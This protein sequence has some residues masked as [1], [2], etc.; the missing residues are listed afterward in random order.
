MLTI[1]LEP[2]AAALFVKHLPVERKV[3]GKR[4]DGF[5]TFAPGSSYIVV[6]AG[7]LQIYLFLFLIQYSQTFKYITFLYI[8]GET[9][10]INDYVLSF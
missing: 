7:G 10:C 3:D 9:V 8:T 2:E 1:A 6:D 4:G 5:K